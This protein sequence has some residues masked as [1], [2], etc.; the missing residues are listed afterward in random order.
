MLQLV[1]MLV[2]ALHLFLLWDRPEKWGEV[3]ISA[4]LALHLL[5]LWVGVQ[6]PIVVVN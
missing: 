5:L 6:F 2:S 4:R 1:L 3:A